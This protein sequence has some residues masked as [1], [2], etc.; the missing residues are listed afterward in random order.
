MRKKIRG[1][2]IAL[3]QTK[4]EVLVPVRVA[5]NAKATVTK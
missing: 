1:R 2:K 5:G 3:I 4:G